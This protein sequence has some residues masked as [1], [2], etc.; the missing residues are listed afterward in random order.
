MPHPDDRPRYREYR[1]PGTAAQDENRVRCS[2]CGFAGISPQAEPGE[3]MNNEGSVS[4]AVT[5]ST[6]V[7]NTVPGTSRAIDVSAQ[8]LEAVVTPDSNRACPD[9]GAERFLDGQRGSAHSV[10]R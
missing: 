4:I 8:D 3:S 5:G 6:Y 7:W 10:R 1:G 2:V 9:C